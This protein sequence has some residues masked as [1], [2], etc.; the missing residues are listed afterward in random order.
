MSGEDAVLII[1]A[2]DSI[3]FAVATGAIAFA[4]AMAISD[5]RWRRDHRPARPARTCPREF[6]RARTVKR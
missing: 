3:A 4:V 6:P 2:T 5:A 1:L